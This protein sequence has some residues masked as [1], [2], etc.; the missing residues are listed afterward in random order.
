R[1]NWIAAESSQ[2]LTLLASVVRTRTPL[3]LGCGYSFFVGLFTLMG[4]TRE[5][6][7][8]LYERERRIS[9]HWPHCSDMNRVAINFEK[10]S[11]SLLRRK[12]WLLLLDGNQNPLGL[13]LE[14]TRT[15]VA[16]LN[17]SPTKGLRLLA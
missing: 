6:V 9:Q 12:K 17:R 16:P 8:N 13:F 14:R 10:G 3:I 1:W 15:N 5:V 4:C 2:T 11:T 7:G